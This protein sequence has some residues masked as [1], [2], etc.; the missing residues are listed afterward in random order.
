MTN[1]GN[2]RAVY[3]RQYLVLVLHFMWVCL[4]CL[5]CGIFFSYNQ[6][7][8]NEWNPGMTDMMAFVQANSAKYDWVYITPDLD[9]AYIHFA[10]HTP[11]DP[12][13]FQTDAVWKKNGFEFVDQYQKYRF[14]HFDGF[15][16]LDPSNVAEL[17]DDQHRRILL[18]NKGPDPK[19]NLI[20]TD[21]DWG[22]RWLWYAREVDLDQAIALFA[23]QPPAPSA[24]PCCNICV[25]AKLDAVI[26]RWSATSVSRRMHSLFSLDARH[27]YP[28]FRSGCCDGALCN[29]ALNCPIC[30]H[31]W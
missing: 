26:I 20:W 4:V 19:T 13:T 1:F 5:G 18:V 8:P 12:Q 22:G 21:V 7:L 14:Q 10:F 6:L 28:I 17:F 11:F 9:L 29:R 15:N 23:A 25:R 16:Y 24:T 31:L 27:D 30:H 3:A 2:H